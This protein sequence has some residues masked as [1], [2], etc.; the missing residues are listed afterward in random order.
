MTEES[1]SPKPASSAVYGTLQSPGAVGIDIHPDERHV[2]FHLRS[3]D[4]GEDIAL[5]FRGDRYDPCCM[6]ALTP[7]L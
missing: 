6:R 2:E 1:T 5:R 3:M 7:A 4:R